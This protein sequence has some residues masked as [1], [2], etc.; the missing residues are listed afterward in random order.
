[1]SVVGAN[2]NSARFAVDRSGNDVRRKPL[3]NRQCVFQVTAC[4]PQGSGQP[5]YIWL[6][7]TLLKFKMRNPD[8]AQL[9]SK[10]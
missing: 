3:E 6:L 4:V 1:M 9:Y 10:N 5:G 7:R 2:L 8:T